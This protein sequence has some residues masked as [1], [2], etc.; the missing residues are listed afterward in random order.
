MKQLTIEQ[1]KPLDTLYYVM[2]GTTYVAAIWDD[3]DAALDKAKETS[4]TYH[5]VV[6]VRR[7]KANGRILARAQHGRCKEQR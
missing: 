1:C 4:R 6:T 3:F 7:N 5:Q 2:R